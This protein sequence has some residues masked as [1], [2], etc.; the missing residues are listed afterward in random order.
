MRPALIA[1]IAALTVAAAPAFAKPRLSQEDQLTKALAGR[2]P[3]PP[4]DCIQQRDIDSTRIFDRTAVLYEMR[5]GTYYLNRPK[6]GAESLNWD[7]ILVTDTHSS[8]L[9]QHRRGQALRPRRADADRVSST[10]T[11]SCPTPSRSSGTRQVARAH[12]VISQA[13][14]STAVSSDT[15]FITWSTGP[16]MPRCV[17]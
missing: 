5:G 8:Q 11:S 4:V 6:G 13:E 1:A 12:R 3:G 17:R 16:Y 9:W 10:S 14:H 7:K 2:V 15:T